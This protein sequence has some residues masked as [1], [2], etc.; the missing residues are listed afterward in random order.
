MSD[1]S[2]IVCKQMQCLCLLTIHTTQCSLLKPLFCYYPILR[3]VTHGCF[4]TQHP[5]PPPKNVFF[6]E[7]PGHMIL[8][9]ENKE[10]FK[11]KT[12][13]CILPSHFHFPHSS[14]FCGTKLLKHL[15]IPLSWGWKRAEN[16]PFP[17]RKTCRWREHFCLISGQ[18]PSRYQLKL[19]RQVHHWLWSRPLFQFLRWRNRRSAS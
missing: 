11:T 19:A 10:G 17:P 3:V 18:D 8:L 12:Q 4:L 2:D 7:C 15:P 5:L 9:V 13:R 6:E 16:L 1:S 14:S